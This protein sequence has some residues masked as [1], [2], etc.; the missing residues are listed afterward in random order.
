MKSIRIFVLTAI[1]AS[2]TASLA[3]AHPVTPRVDR[4]QAWQHAR[5]HQGVRS[6]QLTRAERVRLRAGQARI[7]RMERIAKADGIVTR[8]ERARLARAQAKQ[9][10]MI[11]RFRHNGRMV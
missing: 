1:L 10:R 9:S 7:Q 11:L 6:G 5:I 3:A 4:R 2:V 8:A